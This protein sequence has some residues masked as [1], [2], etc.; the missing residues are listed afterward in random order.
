MIL[1]ILESPYSGVIWRNELYGRMCMLDSLKRGEAPYASHLLY[2]QCLDDHNPEQRDRGM[3]AG[4][5]WGE[6][7]DLRAFYCDRGFSRG[8]IEGLKQACLYRQ[9]LAFRSLPEWRE[10]KR[11]RDTLRQINAWALLN[12]CPC[13]VKEWP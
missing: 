10:E 8:M 7:A 4:F 6:F 5:A 3:R 9:P 12:E 2:T 13:E 1:T 11:L